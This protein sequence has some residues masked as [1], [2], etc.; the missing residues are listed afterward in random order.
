MSTSGS[1]PSAGSSAARH[2]AALAAKADQAIATV[3]AA[4]RPDGYLNSFVQVV[5]G[6]R[7][8]RDLAWGHELYCIGHLVQAAASPGIGRLGDDRL[9]DIGR[10]AA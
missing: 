5:G 6:G 9:L 3:A 10:R 1:R 2:D 8:F 4:Q 7:A